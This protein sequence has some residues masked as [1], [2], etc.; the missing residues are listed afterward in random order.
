MDPTYS[1]FHLLRLFVRDYTFD[2]VG[3]GERW[4]QEEGSANIIGESFCVLRPPHL[5]LPLFATFEAL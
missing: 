5:V 3:H 2:C 1:D 4:I